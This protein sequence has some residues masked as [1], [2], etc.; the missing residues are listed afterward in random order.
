MRTIFR[1]RI[2]L[3]AALA[4]TVGACTAIPDVPIVNN[5]PAKR[6]GTVVAVGEPVWT[7]RVVVT[8]MEVHEDSR[9][10]MNAR[11]VWAGRAIVLTRIDG[12]GWREQA[13]MTLGEPY[14]THGTSVTLTSLNPSQMAGTEIRA[15]DYRFAYEG[16]D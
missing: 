2:A 15:S 12:A 5:G 11:C 14:E 8:P 13:Y 16:G 3:L 6:A 4:A 7:G 1:P 10:P 9:C